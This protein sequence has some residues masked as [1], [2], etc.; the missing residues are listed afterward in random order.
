MNRVARLR[1]YLVD[2]GM[3]SAS[4]EG[5]IAVTLAIGDVPRDRAKLTRRY[6]V[7]LGDTPQFS[8][9]FIPRPWGF[10]FA[11]ILKTYTL[12]SQFTAFRIP[13]LLGHF[14]SEEGHFFVEEY[15]GHATPLSRLVDEGACT[16]AEAREVIKGILSEI[17]TSGETPSESFVRA[18]KARYRNYLERFVKAGL[19]ADITADYLERIVDAHA[20][21]LRRVWSAGDIIDKNIVKSGG[22]WYL[23][24]FEYA[25][26]TLFF[27]KEAFRTILISEWARDLTL[28][29]LCSFLGD[30]PEAA[31]RLLALTWERHLYSLVLDKHADQSAEESL[32]HRLFQ[33]FDAELVHSSDQRIARAQQ[34]LAAKD[35]RLRQLH[36][37]LQGHAELL[38][39]SESE[40]QQLAEETAGSQRRATESEAHA[41][42]LAAEISRLQIQ[43]ANLQ[44]HARNLQAEVARLRDAEDRARRFEAELVPLRGAYESTRAHAHN[45]EAELARLRDVEDRACRLDAQLVEL[46]GA[47]ESTQAHARGLAAEAE[48]LHT[49]EGNLRARIGDLE[50]D[51]SR[52]QE[53]RSR[54]QSLEAE[55]SQLQEGIAQRELELAETTRQLAEHSRVLDAIAHS[56]SWRLTRPLRWLPNQI[57]ALRK[58]RSAS[59]PAASSHGTTSTETDPPPVSRSQIPNGSSSTEPPANRLRYHVDVFR[60]IRTP[61]HDSRILEV[62]GWCFAPSRPDPV[63]LEL[64]ADGHTLLAWICTLERQDV[65]AVWGPQLG[66][67]S[68]LPFC[69]FT[70]MVDLADGAYQRLQLMSADDH[71]TLAQMTVEEFEPADD[72]ADDGAEAEFRHVR[73]ADFVRQVRRQ[74]RAKV[75]YRTAFSPTK[76]RQW[77]RRTADEYRLYRVESQ[78]A[79]SPAA[80]DVSGPTAAAVEVENADAPIDDAALN[81]RVLKVACFTHNL[82]VE[83][84]T[85]VLLDTVLGLHSSGRVAPVVVSPFDGPARQRMETRGVPCHIIHLHGTENI[86]AGWR[87]RRDYQKS[88]DTVC[89]FLTREKP[90]V[91]IAIVLNNFF[92]IEAA[93]RLSIPSLWL[94]QESYD[95]PSMIRSVNPFALPAVERAF[96]LA[97]RVVFASK[98][99]KALYERYNQKQNFRVIHNAL[100]PEDMAVVSAES[101]REEARRLL[102]IPMEKKVILSVGTV[103]ARKDQATL[104]RGLGRLAQ[105]RDDFLAY[106][107]GARPADPYARSVAEIIDTYGA[108]ERVKLV[109]ETADVHT[110]YRAADLFAFAS[111]TESFPLVILE[112]M[113]H[114]LPIVTTRCIGVT[115]QVRFGR[116]ALAFE[117]G[118]A[119]GCAT[120]VDHLLDDRARRESMGRSSREILAGVQSYDDTIRQYR[121]LVVAAHNA[122]SDLSGRHKL[123][124]LPQASAAVHVGAGQRSK[125]VSRIPRVSRALRYHVDRFD[126]AADPFSGDRFLYVVGWCYAP[127]IRSPMTLAVRHNGREILTPSCDIVREDVVAALGASVGQ[128]SS[129]PRCGFADQVMFEEHSG[130]LEL[131][132][133]ANGVTLARG[134][135]A[136]LESRVRQ[137]LRRAPKPS[138]LG[139]EEASEPERHPAADENL[140]RNTEGF[141]ALEALRRH[142]PKV[143]FFSHTLGLEGVPKLVLRIAAGLKAEGL[144]RPLLVSPVDGPMR[145]EVEQAGLCLDTWQIDAAPSVFHGWQTLADYR[146]SVASVADAL[147][148]EAPDVIVVNTLHSF[149]VVN[150]AAEVG[151]PCIWTIHEHYD[152]ATMSRHI[153]ACAREACEEAFGHAHRVVFVS[154]DTYRLYRR[155]DGKGNFRVVHNGIDASKID[156]LI[157]ALSRE[158]ARQRQEL[159]V[160]DKAVFLSVGTVCSRKDQLTLL[161]ACQLLAEQRQDFFALVVGPGDADPYFRM[162]SRHAKDS[163]AADL[164]RIVPGTRDIGVYYRAADVFVLTSLVESFSLAMLEAMAYGLPVV[165]TPCGGVNEQVR[166]GSNALRIPFRDA[167][168]LAGAMT[169]LLDDEPRRRKMGRLSRE[170][171][172]EK[173]TEE[174]M[175]AAYGALILSA[176]RGTTQT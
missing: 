66:S 104:A 132:C 95:R 3:V 147:R 73:F 90:D 1:R 119:E 169:T 80:F 5:S 165:T 88:I 139:G 152:D 94:I 79:A 31:A 96:G 164:F 130:D 105:R 39:R 20:A 35:E 17:W 133:P 46:R 112:A 74:A 4:Q 26:E 157:A 115:E 108:A 118:D 153:S 9:K 142:P 103:C 120:Q 7:A 42:N 141:V 135:V 146:R 34:E 125:K 54:A 114:G 82:N 171:F 23:T 99:T 45:L 131:T 63:R 59:G 102:G 27:F 38:A 36:D 6:V 126:I 106:I 50:A 127:G 64:Q 123:A 149:F 18:E 83:G 70:E 55:V 143:L 124:H 76:W 48:R 32:R 44:A 75:S 163:I 138:A 65:A 134:S 161:R 69:G 49:Q 173:H 15:L 151:I 37:A 8:V 155:Y 13:R 62:S 2:Q 10:E 77:L 101:G 81:G 22:S 85:K 150:A 61:P 172:E 121:E 86:L 29:Q 128:N 159:P 16:A 19:L 162:L 156:A 89:E 110:Y 107:V 91:V 67:P 14:E 93:A 160:S 100:T 24:D 72:P 116:N 111:L 145:G 57:R 21:N 113:A 129:L 84:A 117:F 47:Y 87:N 53:A 109:P 71:Q 154:R 137:P 43:E 12:Y 28:G 41:R 51:V 176:Y 166:F 60:I 40:K 52:L 78:M 136:A 148:R 167:P 97:Y 168:A 56:R 140:E 33:T 158:E 175:L 11:D 68:C 92:V 144:L 174:Q 25:H 170:V 122:A 30:F 58:R 98:G